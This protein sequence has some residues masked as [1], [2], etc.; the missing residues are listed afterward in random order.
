MGKDDFICECSPA[1]GRRFKK[2]AITCEKES[3]EIDNMHIAQ[4]AIRISSALVVVVFT[5]EIYCICCSCLY[6]RNIRYFPV[7]ISFFHTKPSFYVYTKSSDPSI[8][9]TEGIW[10]V[11]GKCNCVCVRMCTKGECT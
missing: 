5:I 10:K 9:S 7:L 1:F 2:M 4:D 3:H 6:S 8:I 11:G